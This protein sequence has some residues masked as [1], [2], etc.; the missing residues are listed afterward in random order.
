MS[1]V[2]AVA[3]QF[4]P[5]QGTL[6]TT[7]VLAPTP[8]PGVFTLTFSSVGHVSYLGR[9]TGSSVHTVDQTVSPALQYGT[10]TYIAA[11]GD[12]L[13][14]TYSGTASPPDVNGVIQFSGT[15]TFTGGTGRFNGA[16]GSTTLQGTANVYTGIGQF[17]FSGII[18]K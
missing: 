4:V 10:N 13:F 16:T 2:P 15:Q 12:S 7:F 3:Q 8:V 17:T 18:S 6:T 9:T 1:A 14:S 5:I 11:N